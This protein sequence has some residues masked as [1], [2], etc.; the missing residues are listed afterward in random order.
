MEI[1]DI[2]GDR[3]VQEVVPKY[4][5]RCA[6]LV[7]L[8]DSPG[9]L[10]AARKIID[11]VD[12]PPWEP[13]GEATLVP[14]EKHQALIDDGR[15]GPEL[16]KRIQ[17]ERDDSKIWMNNRY[18]VSVTENKNDA[19]DVS[20]CLSIKN[21]DKSARHDWRDFQRIKNELLG[22]EEE[23]VELYPAESRLVDTANQFF[24]WSLAGMQIPF[25]FRE[26]LIATE[27][28]ADLFGARQRP[29][30]GGSVPEDAIALTPEKMDQLYREIHERTKAEG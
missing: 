14:N 15:I 18:Q 11:I 9:G 22:A 7:R 17:E 24:L 4:C 6:R 29:F 23:A 10:E 19:G 30:D 13:L 3:T 5:P 2:C 21:L 25:G 26:R 16:L 12:R 20:Y 1:C 8:M 28:E 27:Q